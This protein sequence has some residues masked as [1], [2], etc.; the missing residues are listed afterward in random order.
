MR[1]HLW[2]VTVPVI[3]GVLLLVPA[4][5]GNAAGNSM[6]WTT[7]DATRV[8]TVMVDKMG[9]VNVSGTVACSATHAAVR[10]A[11]ADGEFFADNLMTGAKDEQVVLGPNDH[12]NLL[13]N[14][15]EYTVT[16]PAGKKTMLMVTHQSSRMNPCFMEEYVDGPAQSNPCATAGAPCRWETDIFGYDRVSLGPLFDYSANG[17][18]KAGT[19]SV[20]AQ[21]IGLGLQIVRSDGSRG[22]YLVENGSYAVTTQTVRAVSYRG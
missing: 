19:M 3:T 10:T 11:I 8:G 7:V 12:V 1:K 20:N 5:L 16:Q 18:F 9:G 6:D 13:A 14:S 2:A 17:Q 4:G 21:S 22:L 15:D